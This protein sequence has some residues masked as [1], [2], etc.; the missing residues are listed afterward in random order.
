M[1]DH[2]ACGYAGVGRAAFDLKGRNNGCHGSA[3]GRKGIGD[4]DGAHARDLPEPLV[5][6]LE[7]LELL[8]RRGVAFSMQVDFGDQRLFGTHAERSLELVD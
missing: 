1:D 8:R 7:K 4:G 3:S 2:S 6:G 5:E